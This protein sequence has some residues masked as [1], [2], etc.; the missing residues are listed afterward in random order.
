MAQPKIQIEQLI[1][2]I[3]QLT[4][5]Y[6]LSPQPLSKDTVDP[7]PVTH[8]TLSSNSLVLDISVVKTFSILRDRN[9]DSIN[10]KN[11]HPVESIT[12]TLISGGCYCVVW[13]T[14]VKWPNGIAPTLSS[15]E[16]HLDIITL[17]TIDGG[18][19]FS[20]LIQGLDLF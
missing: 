3:E 10:F 6:V 5:S 11:V 2:R 15:V 17:Y 9:I 18:V 20:G 1:G 13:P 4:D 8:T 19:S 12:L 16:Y 7:T 14:N